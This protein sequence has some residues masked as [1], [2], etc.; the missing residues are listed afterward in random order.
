M[1]GC[2]D[3][4][5]QHWRPLME[6]QALWSILKILLWSWFFLKIGQCM[7]DPEGKGAPIVPI[8]LTLWTVLSFSTKIPHGHLGLGSSIRTLN[9]STAGEE[10][11]WIWFLKGQTALNQ[12]ES[13]WRH[14]DPASYLRPDTF[15]VYQHNVNNVPEP[16]PLI[17]A[18]VSQLA[19][20]D[21]MIHLQSFTLTCW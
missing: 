18:L 16:S 4:K 20:C 17:Q 5:T 2:F 1:R 8:S 6:S 13:W 9:S 12:R 10:I 14:F 21:F 11:V 7:N 15:S 3:Q 19:V